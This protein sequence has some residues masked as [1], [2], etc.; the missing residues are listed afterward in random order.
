MVPRIRGPKEFYDS[1]TARYHDFE[2][3]ID[4]GR[5]GVPELTDF[6]LMERQK[7]EAMKGNILYIGAG[8]ASHL[9]PLAKN[10]CR[11]VALEISQ[12]M[13][14]LSKANLQDAGVPVTIIAQK[15]AK[16]GIEEFLQGGKG[17]LLVHGD[18]RKIGLPNGFDHA[19]SFCTLPLMGRFLGW[20]NVLKK[21]ARSA[22]NVVVSVYSRE[23]L[24]KL[25]AAYSRFGFVP[26]IRGGTIKVKGGFSY[27]VLP[28]ERIND[29]MPGWYKHTEEHP[30]GT[31]YSFKKRVGTAPRGVV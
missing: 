19:V 31:I 13:L 3:A 27:T 21:M 7:L 29:A 18:A 1:N 10:G 15:N 11:V 28:N 23:N 5:I 26:S 8:T 14:E 20:R 9:I 2:R 4:E 22:N 16:A 17:V 12:H 25:A 30:M 6:R 24:G